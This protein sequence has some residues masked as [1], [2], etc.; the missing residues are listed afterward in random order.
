MIREL[1]F[2]YRVVLIVITQRVTLLLHLLPIP[3][4][5]SKHL[6]F[7]HS[8]QLMIFINISNEYQRTQRNFVGS[9][10]LVFFVNIL[11]SV[12]KCFTQESTIIFYQ[13]KY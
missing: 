1:I 2:K 4:T 13:Y 8:L 6:T 11:T 12:A 7:L 3:T 9:L 5:C 10:W